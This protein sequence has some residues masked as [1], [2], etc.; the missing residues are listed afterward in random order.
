MCRCRCNVALSS[1]PCCCGRDNRALGKFGRAVDFISAC[2]FK[3]NISIFLHTYMSDNMGFCSLGSRGQPPDRYSHA[4]NSGCTAVSQIMSSK[5]FVFGMRQ[6]LCGYAGTYNCFVHLLYFALFYLNMP[7]STIIF[8]CIST[9]IFVVRVH[10][11]REQAGA[12]KKSCS[13]WRPCS[14][15]S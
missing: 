12:S 7:I 8:V 14:T 2:D 5:W 6:F 11:M 15:R 3:N 10:F 1:S 9:C 13:L 4:W